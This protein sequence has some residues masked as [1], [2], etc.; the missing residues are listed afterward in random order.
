MNKN[1]NH[2]PVFF[3]GIKLCF[4]IFIGMGMAMFLAEFAAIQ[5]DWI[6]LLIPVLLS[7]VICAALVLFVRS[8]LSCMLIAGGLWLVFV[9]INKTAI[10]GGAQ[11]VYA[12]AE[13]M[14]SAYF[15]NGITFSFWTFP[16]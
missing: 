11:T 8:K 6:E 16:G 3:A 15:N 9:W 7:A 14:V 5:R 2:V 13:N 4:L 1:E 10:Y 12:I